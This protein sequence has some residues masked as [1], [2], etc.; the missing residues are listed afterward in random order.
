MIINEIIK[1]EFNFNFDTINNIDI[2]NIFTDKL[3]IK[4]TYTKL[5]IHGKSKNK[6]NSFHK[7]YKVNG[8]NIKSKIKEISSKNNDQIFIYETNKYDYYLILD[9]IFYRD[10]N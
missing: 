10:L 3:I 8:D 4:S 5:G 9:N 2:I 7:N 6:F 1:T